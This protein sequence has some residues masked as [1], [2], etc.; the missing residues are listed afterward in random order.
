M[1][2]QQDRY[3]LDERFEMRVEDAARL[4]AARGAGGDS[5]APPFVLIDIREAEE[6]AIASIEHAVWIPMG[7]LGTR[8]NEIDAGE[9]GTIGLICHTGRRSLAAAI[10]LQRAGL[11]EVRSVAGG[12]E[13]WSLRVDAGVPRY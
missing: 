11:D 9:E 6:L 4:H 3:P 2:G 1:N 10:A 5:G 12:I 7:E 8:I 13:A